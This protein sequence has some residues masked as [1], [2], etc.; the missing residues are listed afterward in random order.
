M[1]GNAHMPTPNHNNDYVVHTLII[2]LSIPVAII[3]AITGHPFIAGA[4]AI[5]FILAITG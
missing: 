4:A 1:S 5:A 3:A 2:W